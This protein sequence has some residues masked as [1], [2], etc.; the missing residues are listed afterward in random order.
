MAVP[1]GEQRKLWALSG[2]RCAFTE[3]RHELVMRPA[4]SDELIVL[5]HAA[6][7]VGASER[8]P[9]GT[10]ELSRTERD[11][12]DNLI[13]LCNIHH[14][15]VDAQPE[16]FTPERLNAMKE[17]HE[18]WVRGRL[19]TG[20][21]VVVSDPPYVQS[22]VY[23]TLLPVRQMPKFVYGAESRC[24]T[25][26]EVR[27]RM[28]SLR[29]GE[30]A[31]FVL[32][33]SRLFAFQQLS[34]PN[35]PFSEVIDGRVEK[36]RVEQWALHPD[37]S[38]WLVDLLNRTLN[39][40][41]GRRGLELDKEHHRYFFPMTEPGEP[42]DISYRPLNASS[43]TRKVVWQPITRA[44]G[45][46]KKHWLH[47][48][49]S[50]RFF[51]ASPR[52]WFLSLRPELRVTTDGFA[53]YPSRAVGARITKKKARLFNYDLLGEAQFWRDYLSGS[54]PQIVLPFGTQTQKII[55]S[56]DF[57]ST[58]ITWPGIP[59][60]YEKPFRNVHYVDDLFAWAE[61]DVEGQWDDEGEDV[62]ELEGGGDVAG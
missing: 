31:P 14:Q 45:A 5:G 35:N 20:I 33:D 47:S 37:H 17:A 44:T 56:S 61:A 13:F 10:S 16:R 3:C 49:V 38:K 62:L 1:I 48:A 18:E 27:A 24:K 57:M 58:G 32:R 29:R 41:T 15:I 21:D 59:S 23:S 2:N 19:S 42:V 43:A 46:P 34:A 28:G 52:S 26:S 4:G 6:H 12:Y 25:A 7:I 55:I 22:D 53:V 60:E 51:R 50:L 8:G 36:M 40:L 54:R 9:R 11:S 30:M 39:K